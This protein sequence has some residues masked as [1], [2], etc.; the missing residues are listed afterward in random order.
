[1]KQNEILEGDKLI[2]EFMGMTSSFDTY[3]C[4]SQKCH[5]EV[6]SLNYHSSWDWLMP[7]CKKFND[8]KFEI[9]T[10]KHE[11][12]CDDIIHYISSFQI[13]EVFIALVYAIKWHNSLNSKI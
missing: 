12:I 6:N 8:I 1:M 5:F 9:E 4:K 7:A 2:A 10:P 13:E 11:L 3:F